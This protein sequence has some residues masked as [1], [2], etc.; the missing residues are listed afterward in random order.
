MKRV[1]LSMAIPVLAVCFVLCAL[2]SANALSP[3]SPVTAN[4]ST[5]PSVTYTLT[6]TLLG[7]VEIEP[8]DFYAVVGEKVLLGKLPYI[9]IVSNCN[10][11]WQCQITTTAVSTDVPRVYEGIDVG[12][13]RLYEQYQGAVISVT[14]SGTITVLYQPPGQEWSGWGRC[15]GDGTYAYCRKS[16]QG[17]LS[18]L[19]FDTNTPTV[20]YSI[21]T[22]YVWTARDLLVAFMYQARIDDTDGYTVCVSNLRA[23]S[24]TC[25]F[26][27]QSSPSITQEKLALFPH[28]N[29]L[30][31]QIGSHLYTYSVPTLTLQPE[32][33]ITLPLGSYIQA[34]GR[35]WLLV[36]AG[37]YD[38]NVSRLYVYRPQRLQGAVFQ[39][40]FLVPLYLYVR[41]YNDSLAIIGL[42][43]DVGFV[44]FTRP[45]PQFYIYSYRTKGY[46]GVRTLR[47]GDRLIFAYSHHLSVY[48]LTNM[49]ESGRYLL[50]P[51][52]VYTPATDHDHRLLMMGSRYYYLF[53]FS[54]YPPEVVSGT[55]SPDVAS[56]WWK[57]IRGNYAY[58]TCSP[59]QGWPRD[60]STSPDE[61]VV[62]GYPATLD[63]SSMQIASTMNSQMFG[64]FVT[65][66][67]IYAFVTQTVG[68]GIVI[69]V[70]VLSNDPNN[71]SVSQV[72]PNSVSLPNWGW[73][74]SDRYEHSL[75]VWMMDIDDCRWRPYLVKLDLS[76]PRVIT[77]PINSNDQLAG[78]DDL[79]VYLYNLT[80]Q[81]HG[82]S[83]DFTRHYI[84]DSP[85]AFGTLLVAP[86][87]LIVQSSG[88]WV[89]ARPEIS[90]PYKAYLPIVVRSGG[91]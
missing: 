7:H 65:S 59:R 21:T 73:M 86:R 33:E 41:G 61:N 16:V 9:T 89:Y 36:G 48:S 46:P 19:S 40:E 49:A 72:L 67:K 18:V 60:F 55:V 74:Q 5:S 31:V 62:Y 44:D 66:D 25:N 80:G 50:T 14:E 8:G 84:F 11:P 1:A 71:L 10:N 54:S 68:T 83:H 64:P 82:F 77:T 28:L 32:E 79:Y 37:S 3:T 4:V 43:P 24:Q 45:E 78:A 42:E 17:T 2:N 52:E 12:G 6:A 30:Y 15:E 22:P 51:T 47:L 85:P 76:V 63:L 39:K 27:G 26:I 69:T 13:G 81:H 23:G 35:D 91:N 87:L 75:F 20:I 29:T 34:Y 58:G 88:C 57:A 70:S 53:D 38:P 56:C 90:F